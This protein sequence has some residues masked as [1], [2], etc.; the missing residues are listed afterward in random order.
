MQGKNV[1][2]QGY[3]NI[4]TSQNTADM[5]KDNYLAKKRISTEPSR[6]KL[7]FT[8]KEIPNFTW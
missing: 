3:C 2:Q 8:P 6:A 5:H 7:P 1:I 4:I